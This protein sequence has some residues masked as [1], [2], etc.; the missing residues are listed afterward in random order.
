MPGADGKIIPCFV[1]EVGLSQDLPD[2]MATAELYLAE[3]HVR[4]VMLLKIVSVATDLDIAKYMYT[5]TLCKVGAGLETTVNFSP[6]RLA[7]STVQAITRATQLGPEQ[8]HGFGYTVP[9]PLTQDEYWFALDHN[10]VFTISV[11][12]NVIWYGFGPAHQ[13]IV[14][15]PYHCN[16]KLKVNLHLSTHLLFFEIPETMEETH[17]EAM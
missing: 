4:M 8:F 17:D 1:L 3:E 12:Q 16:L 7:S 15:Q 6:R 10:P 9:V 5:V 14:L 11:P 13:H 2:L